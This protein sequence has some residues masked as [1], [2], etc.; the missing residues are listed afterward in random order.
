MAKSQQTFRKKENAKQKQIKKKNKKERREFNKTSNNKGK[1]L[2]EM[3]AYVDEFGNISNTPPTE[4]Y[5]FKESDLHKP[6]IN[7]DEFLF[8][9]VSYY[10]EAGHYGF[11]RDNISKETVYFNDSLAG[12]ILRIDQK[13]KY[14]YIRSK[15]GNQISTVELM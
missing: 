10:N 9:K 15:Q 4:V 5:K 3:Y 14:K 2:E 8:G 6:T 1:S 7:E 11:I 13:V 12:M